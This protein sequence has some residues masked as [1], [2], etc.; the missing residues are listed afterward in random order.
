[1][2]TARC[3]LSTVSHDN[4]L[5]IAAGGIAQI[6]CNG[7][8]EKTDTV[9]IYIKE[10]RTWFSTTPLPF[11]TCAFTTCI[12]HNT[13]YI[14]GGTAS[15]AQA[16]ITLHA[17]VPALVENTNSNKTPSPWKEL[18]ERHPL[19]L[20]TPVELDGRLVTIGGSPEIVHR[21]G[22]TFIS[23]YN[24][25]SNAWEE[26]NGATLPVPLY[27]AGVVKLDGNQ[28]MIVG[29]QPKSQQFSAAVYIGSYRTEQET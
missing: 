14:L 23:M 25:D 9:E 7:I 16:C 22:S 2:P 21:R 4:R 12:I 26:C 1:M 15:E 3:L 28:V 18:R 29:G 20:S 5:I 27:R 13:C 10:S 8:L 6:E 24:F 17:P 19:N 11:P